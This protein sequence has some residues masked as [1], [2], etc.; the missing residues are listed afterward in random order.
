MEPQVGD[1]VVCNQYPNNLA[2]QRFTSNNDGD[3]WIVVRPEPTEPL[4]LIDLTGPDY[5]CDFEAVRA[6]GDII[7]VKRNSIT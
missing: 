3:G 5:E 7:V 6:N 1:I 4:L 2:F